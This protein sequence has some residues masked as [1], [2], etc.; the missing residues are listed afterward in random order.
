M[1]LK[2][3]D[4]EDSAWLRRV[5]L[6]RR[7]RDPNWGSPITWARLGLEL[8]LPGSAATTP[9]Y[10]VSLVLT[11]GSVEEASWFRDQAS[12]ESL[13]TSLLKSTPRTDDAPRSGVGRRRV[14]LLDVDS[15][16]QAVT[17]RGASSIRVSA[18]GWA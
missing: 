16:A 10:L 18:T 3:W 15:V 13:V 12:A 7:M 9:R 4:V 17:A 14:E 8:A 1:I 11:D 6:E 2:S 5:I